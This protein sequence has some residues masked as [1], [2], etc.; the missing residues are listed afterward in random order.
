MIISSRAG[1]MMPAPPWRTRQRLHDQASR[2]QSRCQRRIQGEA[3]QLNRS[4]RSLPRPQP[5]GSRL[6]RAAR[7]HPT[8]SPC[9]RRGP[10]ECV[11][12]A[13][14][15]LRLGRSLDDGIGR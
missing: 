8:R 11:S 3:S 2:R 9:Y 14:G 5:A 10:T 7:G 4:A 13:V 15:Q 1:D 6:Q 12:L